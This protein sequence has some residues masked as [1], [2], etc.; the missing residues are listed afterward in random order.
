M[1]GP[2]PSPAHLLTGRRPPL[3][4]SGLRAGAHAGGRR[5][6]VGPRAHDRRRGTR[7]PAPGDLRSPGLRAPARAARRSGRPPRGRRRGRCR[8]RTAGGGRSPPRRRKAAGRPDRLPSGAPSPP[9]SRSR[10]PW[11]RVPPHRS[12]RAVAGR[13]DV[14]TV[15]DVTVGPIKLGA[16]VA[17]QAEATGRSSP[18]APAWTS[19]PSPNRSYLGAS[20][21]P[22]EAWR[23]ERDDSDEG[24]PA[25]R[26]AQW[27]T[28]KVLAPRLKRR[29]EEL[30]SG[31]R[32]PAK[33]W[34]AVRR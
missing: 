17:Q 24:R 5:T 1:A 31:A 33:R 28:T 13:D 14:Y 10:R 2:A 22:G 25:H 27:P 16:I 32:D 3:D 23:L 21:W 7:A 20:C 8:S 26:E 29:L 6:R 11:R 12:R 9:A 18:R 19:R 15:G 30:R 34:G 4:A